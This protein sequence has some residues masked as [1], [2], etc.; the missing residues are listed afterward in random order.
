MNNLYLKYFTTN[1]KL[2]AIL[3]DPEKHSID[4]LKN[5]SRKLASSRI[6]IILIGSSLSSLHYD[7]AIRTIKSICNKPVFLFPGNSLQLSAEAD[8][9][10]NLALISGRNPEFLIGEHVRSAMFLKQLDLEVIPTGYI[11][12]DGGIKTSVEYM[13]NT[14]SIP[15]NKNDIVVATAVAGEYL[16]LKSIYLEAGSGALNPVPVDMIRAIRAQIN[17]PIICGGGIKSMGDIQERWN[18][19]TN[20]VVVGTAFEQNPSLLERL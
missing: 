11:L 19:G 4:E 9:L 7:D 15:N 17:I 16:G 10:L 6:D 2:L 18:S 12:I 3:I 20:I 8:G 1:S 5:L 14:V 13:S